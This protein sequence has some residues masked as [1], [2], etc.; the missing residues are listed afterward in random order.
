M[1]VLEFAITG[2]DS[3]DAAQAFAA[4][5]DHE[6]PFDTV[7]ALF[8]PCTILKPPVAI[9]LSTTGWSG[10]MES[11]PAKDNTICDAEKYAATGIGSEDIESTMSPIEDT[12]SSERTMERGRSYSW[13]P[14]SAQ[15]EEK[16][17]ASL[18]ATRRRLSD[19]C[20]MGAGL[21]DRVHSKHLRVET[22]AVPHQHATV[23][24][25]ESRPATPA[26][27]L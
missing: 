20:G 17:R 6:A 14:R 3:S 5:V 22:Q 2:F 23:A 10:E 12:L 15:P 26:D 13:P 21:N 25:E 24:D 18:E 8:G 9:A 16:F 1:G 7:F 4:E 11:R 27:D 19:L